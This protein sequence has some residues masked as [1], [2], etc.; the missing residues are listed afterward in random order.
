MLTKYADCEVVSFEV[1]SPA[2]IRK[3][4]SFEHI[5]ED[6]FKTKDGFIYVKVRAISS[7]VNKNH[8]GWPVNELAGMKEA[9]FRDL[10]R[11]LDEQDE[12]PSK[13][14][15]TKLSRVFTSSSKE[16]SDEF[17]YKT[18]IGRPIFIDHNNS[19]PRRAR[20]VVV[21]SVLH[22]EPTGKRYSASDYWS[23]AP[24]NHKPETHIE[25]LL[26]VDGKSFPKLARALK[27]G[28]VGDVSMGANVTH[29]ICSICEKTAKTVDDYCS[30]IKR[31]GINYTRA[32][33]RKTSAYEDCYNPN[34][35]EISF[36]FDP[37]DTTARPTGPI[38][39]ASV[40]EAEFRPG[41]VEDKLLKYL[42]DQGMPENEVRQKMLDPNWLQQAYTSYKDLIDKSEYI[43]PG[44]TEADHDWM[45]DMGM[46]WARLDKFASVT[47]PSPE[48]ECPDCNGTGRT[49]MGNCHCPKGR[50]LQHETNETD[51]AEWTVKQAHEDEY[52]E[53]APA[54]EDDDPEKLMRTY[55]EGGQVGAYWNRD[56]E[57]R[58]QARAQA[59][60]YVNAHPEEVTNP[61]G[62]WNHQRMQEIHEQIENDLRRSTPPASEDFS[63]APGEGGLSSSGTWMP[64][65][66]KYRNM[67]FD[68]PEPD[69]NSYDQRFPG[70]RI[71]PNH[72]DRQPSRPKA[73]SPSLDYNANEDNP[74]SAFIP[75]A[76]STYTEGKQSGCT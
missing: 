7:R 75:D 48:G 1:S 16:C 22:I 61:D 65:P 18:F 53:V 64:D 42:T 33:G 50:A 55:P 19:D 58:E 14:S 27:E 63:G 26:E 38:I 43:T 54:G 20:G 66:E 68:L 34:F 67:T 8:D 30:H 36:V 59:G 12:N 41:T 3:T 11:E 25:L 28:R 9:A 39:T 2:E 51:K 29:T 57:V 60:E 32:D 69:P 21:D 49:E 6:R 31:K 47:P 35:F 44:P 10:Q 62:S 4:S 17:G 37:A 73:P 72:P 5:P 23:N 74:H 15:A 70:A 45:N 40:K 46:R 56:R 52:H 71:T 13:E 76:G 24:D